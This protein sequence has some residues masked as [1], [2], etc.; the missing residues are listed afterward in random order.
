MAD[1]DKLRDYLKRAIADARDARRRLQEAEDRTHEPVAIVGMACRFPGGVDSPESLWRLVRDGTDAVGEFPANRGWDLGALY[2]PDPDRTGTSYT[3]WGGFLY[4]ADEFDAGF[5]GMSPREATATDP[6]QRLLL[7]TAWEALEDAGI[8]PGTLRGSRTG[9]FVGAMYS[10]YASRMAKAPGEF[11]GYLFSGSAGSVAAGRLAYTY[12]L[13]GPAVA[14]DTACSSSLVAL[15]LAA[16]ALR[17]GECDLALAGGVTVMSDPVAFI[18][19]SRQRGLAADGR[20]KSFSA[21]ADGTG[22]S[23]GVGLLLVER[24]SDAR[25]NGHRILAVIRGSAVNQDGASNGLTAPN[26]P[27]QERVIRQALA[28]ARLT[29]DAVDAVEAHGTG[30][31]LGDPIEARALLATYGRG[32]ESGPPLWLGS[33][34]SNIGHAQAAAG[35][36]GVIKMVQ[37]MR[38]GQLP[39]TLHADEPTPHI[40]WDTAGIRLLTEHTPWPDTGRPRRAGVSSFGFGGTNAH[41]IVEQAE[42]AHHPEPPA[43]TWTPPLVPWLVSGRDTAGLRAQAARL[44][45]H[46]T[47]D[48]TVRPL[49]VAHTLA[50]TRAALDQRAAV[51]GSTREELLTGL[52]AL[53]GEGS[54]LPPPVHQGALGFV[55]TGQGAQRAH[56]GSELYAA[57]PVFAEAFDTVCAALDPL[58]PR[59]L[60]EVIADGTDLGDTRFTQPALFAVEV[61][62]FRLITSWGIRPDVLAGHSIGELAAA[63]VA[64]V[65]TLDD[66]CVLVAARARLMGALPAGGAMAA[67]EAAE[68]EVLPL[69]AGEDRIAVAAVNGPR[70][71]VV[72]G[73]EPAVER[74]VDRLRSQGRRTRRLTVSHAFH[75]PLMDPMLEEFGKIAAGL[76]YRPPRIPLVSALTGEP[77]DPALLTDPAYWVRHVREPVRFADAVRAMEAEDVSTLLEVGPDAVLAVLAR[78]TLDEDRD[79]LTLPALRRGRPEPDTLLAA[80]GALHTR[81][82]AVDWPAYFA[83]TGAAVVKLPA[84][85]LRRD[86]YWLEPAEQDGGAPGLRPTGHPLLGAAFPLPGSTDRVFTGRLPERAHPWLAEPVTAAAALAETG[87]RAGAE[88]GAAELAEFTLTAPL[89]TPARGAVELQVTVGGPDGEGLR[90]LSIHA[91]PETPDGAAPWTEHARGR[92][93]TPSAAPPSGAGPADGTAVHA[94]LDSA[95]AGRAARFGLH[96]ALLGTVLRDHPFRAAPGTVSVPERWRGLRVHRTG[97][98]AVRAVFTATGERTAAVRLTDEDGRPVATIDALT[99]RDL[100]AARLVPADAGT[101]A[102]PAAPA[103]PGPEPAGPPSAADAPARGPAAGPEERRQAVLTLVRQEVAGVLG[104]RDPHTLALERSFQDAGFDS[105][106]AVQ[107]RDRLSTATG[108]RLPATV[109]FDHPSPAALARYLL[110]ALTAAE[111]GPGTEGPPPLST[112]LDWLE[113]TVAALPAQPEGLDRDAIGARLRTVLHR[114][115]PTAGPTPPPEGPGDAGSRI[116]GASADE[117]FDFIDSELGRGSGR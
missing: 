3:R 24:L 82:V 2:D 59:P 105:M 65:L 29:P 95:L 19:F 89:L 45:T 90:P 77:A 87:L 78:E 5:F 107:L 72:S 12:G 56:M 46:L 110:G 108:L 28:N 70:A 96:P 48:P 109:V 43:A 51:L 92:L 23:E 30:T 103:P 11:E 102:G 16:G 71:V 10:D 38:H 32:R 14:V 100:P 26:G 33:L 114:L 52:A 61:A 76:H 13:E 50:T 66:A 111:A 62:L 101:G 113:A 98:T 4:D 42:P 9:V 6:Q 54:A 7:R 115:A 75:S 86:R 94:R 63:H 60:R 80:V 39:R 112:Q 41:L 83:G 18:E 49:D 93:G 99:Y 37:A 47:A 106:T 81:G 25:R 91:R 67:V 57:F 58:L 104:H 21:A 15:H 64:G 17:Q 40:D 27:S 117:I 79:P 36:G 97:A 55:F 84:Q 88:A 44:H 34:K 22:W 1:E 73:E 74:V 68:D 85:A 31:T 8:V 35:V 53:A 69:L 116:A 20:C